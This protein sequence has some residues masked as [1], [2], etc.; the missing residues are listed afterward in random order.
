MES[1]GKNIVQIGLA[2]AMAGIMMASLSL[3]GISVLLSGEIVR[4]AAGNVFVLL[5][6][7]AMASFVLGLGLPS[8]PCYISVSVLIAP[9]LVQ[10]GISKMAAHL[11]VLWYAIASFITPPEGMAFFVA[12]AVA[13][14]S[15][16]RTG[17]RATLLAIG[18][19]FV[20]FVFVYN[21]GLLFEGSFSS[22]VIAILSASLGMVA[23]SAGI[24][25]FFLKRIGWVRRVLLLASGILIFFPDW[26]PR[27]IGG[28]ALV[29][30][31][32]SLRASRRKDILAT[33]IEP[34]E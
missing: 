3:T 15:P 23:L 13:Q 2:C 31:F 25:G 19:F 26:S 24:E 17:W 5:V 4:I 21:T 28:L 16:M 11:F 1:T 30:I 22:I 18:N 12:A 32:A 6:L 29:V 8:I 33:A 20:P 34:A 9:A 14:S 27:L 7:A 10:M